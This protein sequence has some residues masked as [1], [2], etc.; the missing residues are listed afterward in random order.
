MGADK[1]DD[2]RT[3]ETD[4]AAMWSSDG[5]TRSLAP[6]GTGL[7]TDLPFL[8]PPASVLVDT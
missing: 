8:F 4:F 5:V 1:P 2:T 3:R 6:T 7:P